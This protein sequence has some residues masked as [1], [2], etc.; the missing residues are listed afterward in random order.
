MKSPLPAPCSSWALLAAALLAALPAAL[1][2]QVVP[3]TRRAAAVEASQKLLATRESPLPTD[4][5]NPF[6]PQAFAEIRAGGPVA[7]GPG[8]GADPVTPTQSGPRTDRD[9]L[10]AIATAMRAPN[11]ITLGGEQ[12]LVF[13][14]KRV[15]AGD[16]LT[17]NFEGTDYVLEVTAVDRV[18]FT[19]RL[20]REEYT[21]PIK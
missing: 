15:K 6:Y 16:T 2:S 10:A 14:Q 21:R 12:I 1:W 4:L 18:S 3:P 5:V 11:L 9:L 19:L 7:A 8:V 17:I 13:G 20:N